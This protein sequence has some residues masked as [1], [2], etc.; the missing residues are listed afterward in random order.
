VHVRLPKQT[1]DRPST[2]PLANLV[3]D[4]L[5]VRRSEVGGIIGRLC[6]RLSGSIRI[7]AMIAAHVR[8]ALRSFGSC[9]HTKTRVRELDPVSRREMLEIAEGCDG[10]ARRE[11]ERRRVRSKAWSG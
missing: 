4:S 6:A 5:L 8:C 7:A 10:L 9:V 1:Y 3:I 2:W 11:A